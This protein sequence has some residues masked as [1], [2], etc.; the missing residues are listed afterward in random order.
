MTLDEIQESPTLEINN[1]VLKKIAEGK[2]VISFAIGEPIYDIP[3]E[4]IDAAI[5]GMK[6]G[7][8]HYV[9]SYGIPEVR[10][11]IVNK[12]KRKNHINCDIDNT[13]FISSRM[14]I[15][16]TFMAI[17]EKERNEILIPDPGYFYREPAL[18]AGLKPVPYFLKDD[19][20]LDIDDIQEKN[21]CSHCC[22][23]N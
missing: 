13:I 22:N 2:D 16:A 18:L 23:S 9:S 10:E 3:S 21:K 5:E 7:L 6:S 15:Y 20:S 8:T 4:I 11:A 12:V 14:A 17:G 1:L 19:Y